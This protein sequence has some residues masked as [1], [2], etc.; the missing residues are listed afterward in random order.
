MFFKVFFKH[1]HPSRKWEIGKSE[2]NNLKQYSPNANAVISRE[3]NV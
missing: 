1:D 3:D 2:T